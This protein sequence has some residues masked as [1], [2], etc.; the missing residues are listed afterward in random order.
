M[1]DQNHESLVFVLKMNR[2]SFL[3]TGDADAA[4]EQEILADQQKRGN[5]PDSGLF[6]SPVDVLKIGHHGSKTSTSAEWLAA[7]KPKTAVISAGVNN[8]Y[9]HPHPDVVARIKRYDALI[10]RTDLQGEVQ[11]KVSPKGGISLRT[12]LAHANE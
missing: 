6:P 11:M 3:F 8:M 1:K 9:R 5:S 7:W 2:A 4:A 10:F 12:K